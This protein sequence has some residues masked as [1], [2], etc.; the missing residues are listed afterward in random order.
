MKS[1]EIKCVKVLIKKI[2]F[3]NL[4]L[5]LFFHTYFQTKHSLNLIKLLLN[6]KL[7][8]LLLNIKIIKLPL[9]VKIITTSI[10]FYIIF[11]KLALSDV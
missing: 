11:F 6:I 9:I 10:F 2:N 1:L 5:F 7:I 8:K 4:Y 3:S